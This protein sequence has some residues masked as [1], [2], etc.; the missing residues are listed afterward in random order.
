MC[1]LYNMTPKGT[2][3]RYLGSVGASVDVEDFVQAT[4]GPFQT[5]LMVRPGLPGESAQLVGRL[6]QWGM[7]RTGSAAR[8]PASRAVLTNN[9]RI[10]GIAE[11]PTYRR[12]WAQGQRCLI[13][14]DWY[15]EPNWE[16]GKNIWWRLRRAD[17][18][19]WALAGLWSQWT[20]PQ[21]GELVPNFTMITCNCDGHPL[22][23]RLHKPDPTLPPD[24][25]DK[26]AV[27]HIDPADWSTW[28]HGAQADAQAL[29]RPQATGVFD[30]TDARTTDA[31]LASSARGAGAQGSLL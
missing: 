16:T 23:G 6:G 17:G 24:R 4:V 15:Q 27:A 29:V 5:G 28:L 10:E 31:L 8:R 25:Q 26:R 11:R 12:P 2:A 19:P 7:I 3:E 13:L 9:A 14:A 22:L 18:A 30:L 21:T 20:D 1:N